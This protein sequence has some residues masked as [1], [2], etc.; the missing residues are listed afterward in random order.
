LDA[1]GQQFNT[2]YDMDG[3]IQS[4]TK[5]GTPN[6]TVA[7]YTYYDM[8]DGNLARRGQVATVTDGLSGVVQSI[9]YTATGGGMGQP[10]SVTE[11][12][13]GVAYAYSDY[14]DRY[15]SDYSSGGAYTG[16]WRYTNYI[17]LGAPERPSR[18]F[19]TLNKLT[20]AGATTSE[21]FH[22]QYDSSGRLV[23]SAF[24]Q[25]P[26]TGQTG[27]SSSYPAQ[28]RARA[29]YDYDPGGKLL[30]IEHYWDTWNGGSYTS[31]PILGN[32]S[33]YDAYKLLK[34]TSAFYVKTT[35][36]NTWTLERTE[37]YAYDADLD[38]L[39]GASYNDGL[40]N[41]NVNWTYDAAG[42]RISDTSQPGTWTYD[43]LNRMTASPGATYTN[44]ILGN[45][46]TKNTTSHTWD[47]VNRM[48]SLGTSTYVY[49][50]DGM[51]VSKNVGGA[52]STYRYDGQMGMQD[53]DSSGTTKYGLGARGIDYI[54][55]TTGGGTGGGTTTVA[56][57]V[58]DSHGNM[59]ATLSRNGLNYPT[60]SNRRS[61]DAWG[62]V[63]LGVTT[64]EPTGRY[65]AN[66]GHKQ[67]DE[68][69]LVYMRARFYEPTSGRFVSEDPAIDG[70]NWFAYCGN[71]PITSA[72]PFGKDL[73]EI[74]TVLMNAFNLVQNSGRGC[75]LTIPITDQLKLMIGRLET[76]IS[77]AKLN[78]AALISKGEADMEASAFMGSAAEYQQQVAD[79]EV[80]LG[81][82]DHAYG[83]AAQIGI[84][85]IRAMI[86]LV[87]NNGYLR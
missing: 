35:G 1:S 82:K 74:N 53:T 80:S 68:S 29:F 64:G 18:V 67:D 47:A 59:V 3:Q 84:Q 57:P 77:T 63:R 86:Q 37:S 42:N 24:M 65:C 81:V 79:L 11:T 66:L 17:S 52:V 34:N 28:V 31:A 15:Q 72:D 26:Q 87:E 44:D 19:Q 56:F 20:S 85:V 48:T 5:V 33:T 36:A 73:F 60:V 54:E 9:D 10:N 39:T 30:N 6:V 14:G 62:S 43:N 51:R 71:D 61:F 45:R 7:S 69:G 83:A 25:T 46:L 41:Q 8:N 49:R 2:L 12:N 40:P 13:G 21:E 78:G 50:A 16:R 22:Y 38:Y 55:K 76:V 75:G 32:S 58:Y 23:G 70:A 4:V 27:Y